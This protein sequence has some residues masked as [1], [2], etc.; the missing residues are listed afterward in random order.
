MKSFGLT[1]SVVISGLLIAPAA[2]AQQFGMDQQFDQHLMQQ[3]QGPAAN[4]TA[5]ANTQ[6]YTTQENAWQDIGYVYN[7][8]APLGN[9][10]APIQNS[11]FGAISTF[12]GTSGNWL[13]GSMM[14]GQS[15][16]IVE[17]G[18]QA[19]SGGF[20]RPACGRHGSGGFSGSG[21]GSI[22]YPALP[23]TSTS[24]VDLH[25]AF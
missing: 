14:S 1:L 22:L 2:L 12:K 17:T 20:T 23:P 25:T 21:G 4:S 6:A 24:T 18:L 10:Q 11:P 9:V 7:Q 16:P 3:A 13:Q 8:Y 15:L 19:L 5:A